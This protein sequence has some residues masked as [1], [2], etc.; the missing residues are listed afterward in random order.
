MEHCD[1]IIVVYACYTIEKYA[2]QIKTIN[3][4][5]GKKCESYNKIKLFKVVI[6]LENLGLTIETIISEFNLID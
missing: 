2:E 1:L 4:T 6:D 5:W 3:E